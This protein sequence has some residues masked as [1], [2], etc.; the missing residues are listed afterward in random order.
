MKNL[1]LAAH[2]AR[3]AEMRR[4]RDILHAIGYVVT[5]RWIDQHGGSL[6]EALGEQELN[7]DPR[8]GLPYAL[9]DIEDIQAADTVVSFTNGKGRGGRHVEFGI[10]WAYGKRLII[11]GQREHV[12]HCVPEVTQYDEFDQFLASL[13]ILT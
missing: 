11:V 2:Y 12:F 7:G 1:Y 8:I 13:R 9:K 6:T 10:A 3:N 5:S 4:Y